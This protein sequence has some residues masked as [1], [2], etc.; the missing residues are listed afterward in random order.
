MSTITLPSPIHFRKQADGR[1]GFAYRSI[2]RSRE[3]GSR[4]RR[5]DRQAVWNE[6]CEIEPRL[7]GLE[8]IALRSG[9]GRV[10]FAEI[11]I[12]LRRLLGRNASRSRP[13]RLRSALS[14]NIGECWLHARHQEAGRRR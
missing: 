6:L 10:P 1:G 5:L 9:E 11:K 7:L 12:A 2:A 3:Q 14:Y 13:G 8:A 4:P